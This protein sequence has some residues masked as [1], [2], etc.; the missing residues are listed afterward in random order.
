MVKS[1]AKTMDLLRATSKG[2]HPRV[3]TQSGEGEE[4]SLEGLWALVAHLW[5][6]APPQKHFSLSPLR[7]VPPERAR[8]RVTVE[9]CAS[10]RGHTIIRAEQWAGHRT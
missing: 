7:L 1:V 2:S 5:Q 4:G 9:I 10:A 3:K 6:P 8:T